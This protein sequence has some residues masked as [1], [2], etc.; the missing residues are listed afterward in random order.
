[1]SELKNILAELARPFNDLQWKVQTCGI[2]KSGKEYAVCVPYIDARDAQQRLDQSC[3]WQ[4]DYW[5]VGGITFCKVGVFAD[6]Q[7]LW[8]SDAGSAGGIEKEKSL[9]SDA[10]KRAC[11]KWGI[12]R[13]AYKMPPYV[14]NRIQQIG[15]NKKGE[16][17]YAPLSDDGSVLKS[18]KSLSIYINQK[19]GKNKDTGLKHLAGTDLE[20]IQS[21]E[22]LQERYKE[23]QAIFS[24]KAKALNG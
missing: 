21:I 2:S 19:V 8:R 4:D 1:M 22:D 15:K 10:F 3:I 14:F 20:G 18:G 24:R 13:D 11:V 17:T 7:W 5:D 6:G 9:A 12:N 16:P 23:V